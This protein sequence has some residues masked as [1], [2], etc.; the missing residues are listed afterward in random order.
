MYALTPYLRGLECCTTCYVSKASAPQCRIYTRDLKGFFD[1]FVI[2]TWAGRH[3]GHAFAEVGLS[4]QP[5][6]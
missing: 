3:A 4:F 6:A 5:H 2:A 1:E